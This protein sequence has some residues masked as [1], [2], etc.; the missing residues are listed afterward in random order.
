MAE[1]IT[2]PTPMHLDTLRAALKGHEDKLLA[3]MGQAQRRGADAESLDLFRSDLTRTR[4]IL[5]Q[6]GR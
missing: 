5:R 1:A 6:I 3:A 2:L 4:D